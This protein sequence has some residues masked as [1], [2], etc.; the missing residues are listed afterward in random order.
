MGV[1]K[2][3]M[4]RIGLLIPNL[5]GEYHRLML[6]N[7]QLIAQQKN[8]HLIIFSPL[9]GYDDTISDFLI[10][11]KLARP[12]NLDGLIISSGSMM[13]ILPE[14]EIQK[15]INSF[16]GK[17]VIS[18]SGIFSHSHN[19][20]IDNKAGIS[21]VT[22]HLIT[23]HNRKRIAF[24]KGPSNNKEANDRY[25]SYV[26]TLK[27]NNIPLDESI[28]YEGNFLFPSGNKAVK[29][30]IDVRKAVFDSIVGANDDMILGAFDELKNRGIKVPDDVAIA[31]FDDSRITSTMSPSITTV[32][33]PFFIEAEQAIQSILDLIEEK[34]VQDL[35]Y[36]QA[37]PVY[38]ESCGCELSTQEN[39]SV[40]KSGGFDAIQNRN[41]VEK[42]SVYDRF[43]RFYSIIFNSLSSEGLQEQ[44]EVFFNQINMRFCFIALYNGGKPVFESGN[45]IPPQYSQAYFLINEGKAIRYKQGEAEFLTEQILPDRSLLQDKRQTLVISHL[46]FQREHYG[47]IVYDLPEM[48]PTIL[49][50]INLE[51]TNCFKYINI[52]D[53]INQANR[54]LLDLDRAKTDFF[55]NISHEFRTPLTLI[56]GPVETILEG[57]YGQELNDLKPV[58]NTVLG[59]AN[60]LLKMINTLLDFARIE[61][62]GFKLRKKR[63]NISELIRLY[64]DNTVAGAESRGLKLDFI[65]ATDGCEAMVDG[66]LIEKAF[67]N[68]VSNALK[69]T[70]AGGTVTIH[71]SRTDNEFAISVKD[72]GIGMPEDSLKR[73]FVR[74]TQLDSSVS[75][76][77]EGSGI[78]LA[79]AKEIVEL[80]QGTIE[81]KSKVGAGSEFILKFPI[82]NFSGIKKEESA[83]LKDYLLTGVKIGDKDQFTQPAASMSISNSECEKPKILV[84]DDNADLRFF[85]KS[86]LENQYYVI[87]AE[88]GKEALELAKK[89]HP[90]IILSDIMMPEMSGLELTAAIKMNPELKSTPVIL[91]TSRVGLE[92]RIE[93]L[94]IHADDYMN[95]PFD[96]REMQARIKNLIENR[97][98][99]LE[100]NR[101][102]N[103]MNKDLVLA[104]HVQKSIL[105][106]P[107]LYHSIPWL[108]I[109]VEYI[110][111][112]GHISGDYYN[113]SPLKES[114]CS[115]FLSDASGHGLQAALSTMQIDIAFKES[116]HYRYPDERLEVMN[117]KLSSNPMGINFFTGFLAHIHPDKIIYSSA[118][119]PEQLLLKVR[120]KEVRL[121]KT[122]GQILG[123]LS[124][125]DFSMETQEIETGD[126]LLLFSDGILEQTS[127]EGKEFGMSGLVEIIQNY[128]WS[129][130]L[131]ELNKAIIHNIKTFACGKTFEDD[132]T[133]I[134]IRLR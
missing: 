67:M 121:L 99:S 114:V 104:S 12:D 108:E 89:E 76:K 80:H 131:L 32:R 22:E 64:Y 58:L 81:V 86:L 63:V 78:G 94:E 96:P 60:Q 129:K 48:D 132:I 116:A 57:L 77:Y 103:E 122:K 125:T 31:G 40:K 24:I 49:H 37:E 59:N 42:Y 124:N 38:R 62:G 111:M 69:F 6:H 115:V 33:H 30:F 120:T 36:L 84:A 13:I 90:D 9:R 123:M 107:E 21:G 53:E 8:V 35:C 92:S 98:L 19:I 43:T 10:T 70:P 106:T 52:H 51:L 5:E 39:S 66:D 25:S 15:L 112:N 102:H 133:L 110:P 74:F 128:D 7:L 2:N 50:L 82:G 1:K 95:K 72:T 56:V 18:L 44:L 73:I 113:I 91:L 47:Y 85:I 83:Q 87:L 27:A 71:L 127:S 101:K 130:P 34:P 26:E 79:Y 65:D 20:L 105:T 17:P 75:R 14:K 100:L 97:R 28:V 93:G 119:H 41:N 126:I 61:S 29:E 45:M 68:L 134:T 11:F 46:I 109:I 16:H 117:E 3:S 55:S 23:V 54:R 88:N 118:A 4:L